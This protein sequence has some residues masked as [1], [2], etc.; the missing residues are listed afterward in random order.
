[1][2]TPELAQLKRMSVKKNML[3][4]NLSNEE[5]ILLLSAISLCILSKT[6]FNE[7][8]VN[9]LLSNWLTQTNSFLSIDCAELRRTL[10]DY[11]FWQRDAYG[12]KYSRIE[13]TEMFN[14]DLKH[15][16]KLFEKIDLVKE[17]I[18]HQKEILNERQ[19]KKALYTFG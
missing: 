7:I 6:S 19:R 11:G 4:G 3:L 13:P 12:T 10:I 15:Y 2:Q 5:K 1:M 9:E 17:I 8:Q 14:S 16:L 18:Q